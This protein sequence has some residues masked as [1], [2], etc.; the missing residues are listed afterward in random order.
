MRPSSVVVDGFHA[1][2]LSGKKFDS[3][4]IPDLEI[5]N[6]NSEQDLENLKRK[7]KIDHKMVE[8]E[9]TNNLIQTK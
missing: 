5:Y 9:K 1:E 7:Y 6:C 4:T 2:T 8:A 3:N